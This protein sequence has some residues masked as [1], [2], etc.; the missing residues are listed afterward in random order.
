VTV[1]A[2][3]LLSA[4]LVTARYRLQAVRDEAEGLREQPAGPAPGSE[5]GRPALR[6]DAR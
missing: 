1:V 6:A 5:L 2:V 4:V 3:A